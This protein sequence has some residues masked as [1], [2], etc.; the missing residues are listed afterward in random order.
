MQTTMF[1]RRPMLALLCGAGLAL[2]SPQLLAQSTEPALEVQAQRGSGAAFAA[3]QRDLARF[4]AHQLKT[5]TAITRAE[6]PFDISEIDALKNL[7]VGQGFQ[8]Y[9]IDPAELL[10][11][12]GSMRDMAKATGQWRFVVL[13]G[14][15]PVGLATVEW[16]NGRYETVSYGGAVLAKDVDALMNQHGNSDKSNLRFMRIYQARADL[17]EV[18]DRNDGHIR[19][20]P[21]HSARASLALNADAAPGATPTTTGLVDEAELLQPLRAAIKTNLD[22]AR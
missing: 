18:A 4:A 12:R 13:A 19:F 10:A 3:A 9:T 7:K 6:F 17:L 11:G 1:I 15:Q 5:R 2:A 8:V 14:Q 21:L 22:G 20:A 16:T